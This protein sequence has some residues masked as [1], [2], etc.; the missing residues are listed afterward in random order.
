MTAPGTVGRGGR[1]ALDGSRP[2]RIHVTGV[3]GAGMSAIATVLASMGHRVSGS[4]RVASAAM[5]RLAVLGVEVHVG[6]DPSFVRDAAFVTASPAVDDDNVELVEARRRGIP[7]LRRAEVLAAIT[8]AKRLLA[9]AGT[10][11]KTTTTAMLA[12]A[13]TE[14][15]MRPSF[16]VGAE[17]AGLGAN[18]AWDVGPWVVLEADESYG[19]FCALEPELTVVTNVEPDHLDHYGTFEALRRAFEGLV[20]ATSGQF[21]TSA[22]DPVA[23]QLATRHDRAVTVGEDPSADFCIKE[24]RLG[25]ASSRFVLRSPDAAE[26]A[27]GVGVPGRHNAHHGA[28]VAVAGLLVGAAPDA[29]VGALER[30]RGVPRRFE[31]RGEAHGVAFVDDY[32]HLPGEVEATLATCRLRGPRRVVAVFQPHR[33]SRTAAVGSAFGDAFADADVV[34]VTDVYGA[35]EPPIPGVSGQLVAEAIARCR[36]STP[37]HYWA[38]RDE[39]RAGVSALLRPGDLCCTLGAGDLTTLA[40][41]VMAAWGADPTGTAQGEAP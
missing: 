18:A 4:D 36:P 27:I 25:P 15:R 9:V 39:L 2:L 12:L 19:T 17:V 10:H 40:D 32:A 14:A 33:Y 30:F 38:D 13:L 26:F 41:E 1:P 22:D 28:Q 29:I 34:V 3:G 21:V 7:V 37:V 16:L 5:E 31:L 23:R 11:G 24:L 35:G 6:H 8:A 20:E